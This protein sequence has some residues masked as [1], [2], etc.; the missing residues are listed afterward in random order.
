MVWFFV[1]LFAFVALFVRALWLAG[2]DP[3]VKA[4]V[5]ADEQV[6]QSAQH[7]PSTTT[8]QERVAGIEAA[9]EAPAR[10]LGQVRQMAQPLGYALSDVQRAEAAPGLAFDWVAQELTW[11]SVAARQALQAAWLKDA[12]SGFRAL[13]RVLREAWIEGVHWPSGQTHVQKDKELIELLA[14]RLL[15]VEQRIFRDAQV[16]RALAPHSPER[17]T[18]YTHAVLNKSHESYD[19]DPCGAGHNKIISIED[20]LVLLEQPAHSHPACRCTIDPFPVSSQDRAR[21]QQ[22][23]SLSQSLQA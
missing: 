2:K 8:W 3:R 20:A 1:L 5:E 16:H 17:D 11:P 14:A 4:R 12:N 10:S 18:I 22:F 21:L 23:V 9:R 19:G 7:P 13:T 6:Q 15:H